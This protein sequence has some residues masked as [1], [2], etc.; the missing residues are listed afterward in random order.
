M[1]YFKGV[2]VGFGTVLLGCVAA[3]IAL[4]IRDSWK[5]QGGG[6][7]VSFSLMGLTNHLVHSSVF[8]VFILVLFGA[9]FL[10]S[11]FSEEMSRGADAKWL[12]LG[13]L[14]QGFSWSGKAKLG[15]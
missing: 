6:T 10:P 1:N 3:P 12:D 11:Y 13:G 4:I 15:I 2:L 7:T 8:W 14:R 9:G 5:S